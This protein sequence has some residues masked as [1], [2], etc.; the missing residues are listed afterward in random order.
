L[1]LILFVG[2]ALTALIDPFHPVR[3]E[4]NWIRYW[5]AGALVAAGAFALVSSTRRAHPIAVR[6]IGFLFGVLLLFAGADE[7]F[8]FHERAAVGLAAALNLQSSASANDVPPLVV[9]L[10][11]VGV[12]CGLLLLRY[13]GGDIGEFLRQKR[14]HLPFRLFSFSVITFA[15][16]MSL[17][18]FDVYMQGTVDAVRDAA[19]N[20]ATDEQA[21]LLLALTDVRSLANSIE[22]LL[23]LLASL[24]LLMMVG[25]LFG[26]EALGA[27]NADDAR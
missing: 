11:G 10:L 23:E 9:A 4:M 12:L 21:P 26:F 2:G 25:H 27:D 17:D 24:T 6:F 7:V 19:T 18:S 5:T 13:F 16:A 1:V 20:A 22:E 14:Y 15:V 8:E 3:G